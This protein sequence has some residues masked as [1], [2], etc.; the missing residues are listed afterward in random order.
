MVEIAYDVAK[1]QHEPDGSGSAFQ[2]LQLL[3]NVQ[4]LSAS[5]KLKTNKAPDMIWYLVR[6]GLRGLV[7][8]KST[9]WLQ[10]LPRR[11]GL[12]ATQLI[13]QRQASNQDHSKAFPL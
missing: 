9:A 3:K 13:C 11:R 6:V 5:T 7:R 1:A 4:S 2:L 8:D 10:L 12:P